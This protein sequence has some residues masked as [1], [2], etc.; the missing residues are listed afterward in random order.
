[1]DA[2]QL[3]ADELNQ[4]RAE[5]DQ[6]LAELTE[7]RASV[8][9]AIDEATE[10]MRHNCAAEQ[11]RIWRNGVEHGLTQAL[12]AAQS[13]GGGELAEALAERLMPP[14]AGLSGGVTMPMAA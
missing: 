11:R 13:L 3:L 10:A 6:A 2:L 14:T 8:A 4:A 1:M 7:T 12:H 9:R 5:R